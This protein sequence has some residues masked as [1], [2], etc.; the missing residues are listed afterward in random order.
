MNAHIASCG[1]LVKQNRKDDSNDGIVNSK[2]KPSSRTWTVV[3]QA[4]TQDRHHLLSLHRPRSLSSLTTTPPPLQAPCSTQPRRRPSCVRSKFSVFPDDDDRQAGR[5]ASH[6]WSNLAG[7][8]T[9]QFLCIM[10]ISSSG[11]GPYCS[12]GNFYRRPT[13]LVRNTPLSLEDRSPDRLGLSTKFDAN[14]R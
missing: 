1:Q 6:R 10:C 7:H 12:H 14:R 4:T 8:T 11:Y 3:R 9:S 13:L 2:G 5:K